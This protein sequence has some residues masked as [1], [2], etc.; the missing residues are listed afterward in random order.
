MTYPA[1]FNIA[2]R[3]AIAGACW[4]M[5]GSPLHADVRLPKI[6]TD[7]MVLQQ[8]LPIRIWGW[9][10]A[11]EA[12]NVSF[13]GNSAAAKADTAGRWLVQLPA[14]KADGKP[15]SLVIKGRNAIELKDVL[16]GEVWLGVGQSN[17]SRGLRYA[18]DRVK[19]ERMDFQKLRLFFV[20]L[21]QVPQRE[22]AA[23]TKGWAP[24]THETMNS[25]F[26]HPTAGPYEFSEVTYEFGKAIHEKLGV[27]V[28]LIS[29]AFPGSTAAQWTP[30]ANPDQ[31]FDFN[32]GQPDK[33]PGSMYQSMLLGVPPFTI[34]GV[35]YY[36]GENDASN[37]KYADD[38]QTLL[39]A[40]REKFA[41]PDLPFYMTQLAQTTFGGG[42][43]RVTAV[44]QWL[45]A[46][47][48]HTGLAG[49][50][51]LFEGGKSDPTKTR[52]DAATGFPIIG[53]GDPH[54][55]NKHLVAARLARL[56]LA[57]TYGKRD[58]EEC[59]PMVVSSEARGDKM[60]VKFNHFGKGLK[61]DDG[62]AP[63]WFQ[64]AGE[65]KKFVSA[66][67]KITAAD[68][69]ELHADGVGSPRYF[70]FAW[71]SLARHNLY[72]SDGLPAIAN[73]NDAPPVK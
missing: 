38:L 47:V 4:L 3:A 51:D 25:I 35:I 43:L 11:G 32:S 37:P 22:E 1:P 54:P 64:I 18:K 65:D 73:C 69:V 66:K 45:L 16:L 57:E 6:F 2:T 68:T 53:G 24:A 62:Q 9:A 42:P 7:R 29:S 20:G 15:F 14:M 72:N 34:R 60:F 52:L 19:G 12:V 61:T 13:N 71:H 59:G 44:Q 36:Q 58:G 49:S 30:A 21:D 8:Q 5:M 26:V 55:P 46:N 27:P 56:A 33:G 39:A 70:R 41:Q 50:N 10:D 23:M 40:W 31:H 67:A 63:N 28:G 48:P 17:M